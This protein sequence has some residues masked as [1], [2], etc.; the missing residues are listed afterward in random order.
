MPIANWDIFSPYSSDSCCS[1]KKER[2]QMRHNI[3]H[4]ILV[5][6]RFF[7][8]SCIFLLKAG[9]L[10]KCA[11]T[12]ESGRK[13]TSEIVECIIKYHK[14]YNLYI[15]YLLCN[16]KEKILNIKTQLAWRKYVP[17]S[18]LS[19]LKDA[20]CKAYLMYFLYEVGDIISYV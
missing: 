19:P 6:C 4:C 15:T 7:L 20:V 1:D 8:I 13:N 18:V 12:R 11:Y 16:S 10:S 9:L 3:Q 2:L 5:H 17:D 14:N